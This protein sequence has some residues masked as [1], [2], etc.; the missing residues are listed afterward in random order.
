MKN[1]FELEIKRINL[2]FVYIFKNEYLC[3]MSIS[4]YFQH[5]IINIPKIAGLHNNL[6]SEN[7]FNNQ[8][9]VLTNRKSPYIQNFQYHL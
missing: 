9:V 7:S 8:A 3:V 5:L 2:V 6:M 4:I 1:S